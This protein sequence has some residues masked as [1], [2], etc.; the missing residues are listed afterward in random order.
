MDHSIFI[1]LSIII[2]LAAAISFACKYLRQ[3]LIIGY[4]VT[5][6]L[7]GPSLLNI[8]H[9]HEAFSSFSQI[10][11]A[12][13][14]F[15][16]GLG[17]NASII[18]STGKPI[19]LA[20]LAVILG[21]GTLGFVASGFL[22]LARAD[23]LVLAIALLFSSTIIVIKSLSDKREQSR[24]YG[25]IAIGILLVEDIVATVALL[26]VSGQ[27]DGSGGTGGVAGSAFATLMVRALVLALAL[28][29]SGAFILPRIIHAFAKN[30]ELLF[31]FALAWA[32][33]V[34]AV[35]WWYGFS[36]EVG[37]LFAG[38][39]L[40]HL[41]YAQEISTRLKPLRD[42]F[43]LLFFVE[44]GQNLNFDNLGGV[45]VPAAVLSLVV[46]VAKPLTVLAA[47]GV[48]GY[49]KQ[50]GF[51]AAVH[52]SQISEFSIVLVVLAVDRKIVDAET[53][54][55]V[56]LTAIIT[57][58]LSAYLMKYDDKLYKLLQ[59]PLSIFERGRTKKEVRSLK[60]YPLVLLGYRKGGEEFLNVF[61]SMKRR[62]V[63]IDYDPEVIQ[64]LDDRH[65]PN[66][67]GDISDLEL[68]EELSLHESEL[69]VSTIADVNA[70]LLLL[71]AVMTKGRESIFICHASS[72]EEAVAL[73]EKGASYVLLPHFI[74]SEQASSFIKRNGTDTK[75]FEKYRLR[76]M[77]LLE[78]GTET[79][80]DPTAKKREV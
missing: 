49:T 66:I 44:L 76:H 40:A 47:L 16:I 41:P 23:S 62:F 48:L 79:E 27:G 37:A 38:V 10:G 68:L 51:K 42:F 56:T 58:I 46:M 13:L 54:T 8:V 31:I 17:L 5:G 77:R 63:V 61:K 45:L 35:F 32:F 11:I 6:F 57:I 59:K 12:L 20:F 67:Y 71:D 1:Q 22:G 43:I 52:L 80:V 30:Q 15:V 60:T 70:N 64:D 39:S 14:L 78:L 19:M 72:L 9:D 75:A 36:L 50:T 7:A 28:I 4:I 74:G 55:I 25:Q 21:V 2:G 29:V 24:L 34:A 3:P 69:I 33:G 53:A 18:R 26:F 65:I 73:Y